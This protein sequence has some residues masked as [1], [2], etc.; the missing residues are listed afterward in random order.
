[1]GETTEMQRA[2]ND[3]K[4]KIETRELT[5]ERARALIQDELE[6]EWSKPAE[7]IDTAFVDACE[8]FLT[9][10]DGRKTD[11]HYADNL[12]AIRGQMRKESRKRRMPRF[13]K[14]AATACAM[15]AMLA[16]VALIPGGMVDVL[17]LAGNDHTRRLEEMQDNPQNN[18]IGEA[19]EGAYREVIPL[20]KETLTLSQAEEKNIA[21]EDGRLRVLA[22]TYADVDDMGGIY[23]MLALI[24]NT[25]DSEWTASGMY[26]VGFNAAEERLKTAYD[27]RGNTVIPAGGKALLSVEIEEGAMDDAERFELWLDGCETDSAIKQEASADLRDHY[28]VATLTEDDT[29]GEEANGY[30]SAWAFD[31]DGMLLDGFSASL[32]EGEQI[33]AGESWIFEKRIG[34]WVTPEQEED[35]RVEAAGYKMNLENQ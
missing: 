15:A 21:T 24:E 13:G 28:F 2:L 27:V 12:R 8:T 17:G 14:L 20:E 3:I 34:S 26:L 1:M 19:P 22:Q 33:L 35:A 16:V 31:T 11:S 30:L 5:A 9:A 18:A 7:D 23:M 25:T 6:R 10:L 32:E 4:R 29:D